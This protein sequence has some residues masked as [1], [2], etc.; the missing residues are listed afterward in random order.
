[1]CIQSA[2]TRIGRVR[3]ANMKKPNRIERASSQ[4]TCWGGL[5]PD[6]TGLERN[7]VGRGL[8]YVTTCE[9]PL[10]EWLLDAKTW[11]R[12]RARRWKRRRCWGSGITNGSIFFV[13]VVRVACTRQ[14]HAWISFAG[15]ALVHIEKPVRTQSNWIEL[16]ANWFKQFALNAHWIQFAVRTG[17]KSVFTFDSLKCAFQ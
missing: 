14:G 13:N 10:W 9:L 17:L 4:S 2:S 6:W 11:R 16:D 1:M 15:F 7:V 3:T 5:K 12:K 8:Q